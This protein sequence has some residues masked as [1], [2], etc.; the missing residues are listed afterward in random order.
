MPRKQHFHHQTR[1][2]T[3]RS[4]VCDECGQRTIDLH[5]RCLDCGIQLCLDC[6]RKEPGGVAAEVSARETAQKDA[7]DEKATDKKTSKKTEESGATKDDTTGNSVSDSESLLSSEPTTSPAAKN[8]TTTKMAA[9]RLTRGSTQRATRTNPPRQTR[10]GGK[11]KMPAPKQQRKQPAKSKKQDE[12][13]ERDIESKEVEEVKESKGDREK[14]DG[15]ESDHSSDSTILDPSMWKDGQMIDTTMTDI[16]VKATDTEMTDAS[17]TKVDT[18]AQEA[19]NILLSIRKEADSILER[20]ERLEKAGSHEASPR[21]QLPPIYDPRLPDPF[22]SESDRAFTMPWL[23]KNQ[24]DREPHWTEMLGHVPHL[25]KSMS[26]TQGRANSVPGREAGHYLPGPWL[27]SHRPAGSFVGAQGHAPHSQPLSSHAQNQ[28]MFFSDQNGYHE[29]MSDRMYAAMQNSYLSQRQDMAMA[30]AS[31]V[32]FEYLIPGMPGWGEHHYQQQRLPVRGQD[33]GNFNNMHAEYNTQGQWPGRSQQM[34]SF[35]GQ[36]M[37]G[38][39]QMR[40]EYHAPGY[41]VSRMRPMPPVSSHAMPG[42]SQLYAQQTTQS[43]VPPRTQQVPSGMGQANSGGEYSDPSKAW[44]Y[45][46][47]THPPKDTPSIHGQVH[48]GQEQTG[49]QGNMQS[50][51]APRMPVQSPSF[52]ILSL[53]PNRVT[54]LGKYQELAAGHWPL[55]QPQS[56]GGRPGFEPNR[57]GRA[58]PPARRRS[59]SPIRNQAAVGSDR[60]RPQENTQGQASSINWNERIFEGPK[61]KPK[62]TH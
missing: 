45:R 28:I 61:N 59:M 54:E 5:I 40:A 31:K 58:P 23:P 37:P 41:S 46:G 38:A 16:D 55:N 21:P 12:E 24:P 57:Q 3:V 53:H 2:V 1:L 20:I 22:H 19:A 33:A 4:A 26:Y 9:T 43:R 7:G 6:M 11:K 49:F 15:H 18:E 39:A 47:Q 36:E 13:E 32:R 17:S 48:V 56:S 62:D 51:W 14:S 10:G 52:D 30:D 34:G 50:Y 8:E 25:P 44:S 60:S 42:T 27:G 35:Q 29:G